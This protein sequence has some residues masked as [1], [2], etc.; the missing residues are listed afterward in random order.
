MRRRLSARILVIDPAN[1][2][3]LFRFV[4]RGD[5]LDGKVYWATPG[6]ELEGGETFEDAARRELAEETGLAAQF[7]NPEIAR[8][9]TVL[10]LP[11]GETVIADE[12]YFVFRS[13]DGHIDWKGLTASEMRVI[14]SHK[15][16][17]RNDLSQS[18]DQFWPENIGEIFDKALIA[19]L[20]S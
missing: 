15:W 11:D 9:E 13:H 5:A 12:R 7:I 2:L 6:G 4:H 3:L 17:S 20:N 16:W 10:T 18:I 14:Q 1:R 19:P 8:R